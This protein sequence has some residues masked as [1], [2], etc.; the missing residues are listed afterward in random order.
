MKNEVS[1]IGYGSG[2]LLSVRRAFEAIG[3]NVKIASRPEEVLAASRL[4]LPGV[5]AFP[6]GM[7]KLIESNL[8]ES[9][10]KAKLRGTPILG[11]C[12]GMQMLLSESNEFTKTTGLNYIPG[13]VTR[14]NEVLR[15]GE[16]R[17]PRIGWF[18]ISENNNSE[19]LIITR[20]IESS[21]SFYFVHSFM[22]HE[23]E[24]SH[25]VATTKITHG[26]TAPAIIA[27]ENVIGTQFH[28]E[29]SGKAGLEILK[30][31]I[32]FKN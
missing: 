20:G 15:E 17:V 11:I 27:S 22:A 26:L 12:L 6:N 21:E 10:E 16:V 30:N 5:G 25:L 28:P 2:N 13:R 8:V 32:K 23:I 3:C 4:V 19:S 18:K 29:K 24:S 14:I 7:G 1:I 9:L 31:F